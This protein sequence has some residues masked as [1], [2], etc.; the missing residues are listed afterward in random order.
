MS[1]CKARRRYLDLIRGMVIQ[2]VEAG[3]PYVEINC[4][5]AA[6][7]L[8]FGKLLSR[9][10]H[11]ETENCYSIVETENCYGIVETENCYSIL[12]TEKLQNYGD[13]KATELWRQSESSIMQTEY[14][15]NVDREKNDKIRETE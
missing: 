3:I 15:R 7:C 11:M 1:K 12:E 4:W 2:H 14:G 9:G 5:T 10:V 6:D 8:G 13:R